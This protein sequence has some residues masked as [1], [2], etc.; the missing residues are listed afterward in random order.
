MSGGDTIGS[1]QAFFLLLARGLEENRPFSEGR[2]VTLE[3]VT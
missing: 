1:R 2:T 3:N